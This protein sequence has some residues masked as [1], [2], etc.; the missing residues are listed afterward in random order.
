VAACAP[1]GE[2]GAHLLLPPGFGAAGVAHLA[3]EPSLAV[4]L[5]AV[6]QAEE[7]LLWDAADAEDELA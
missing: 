4:E 3:L 1:G 6:T 2:A 7:L 5:A